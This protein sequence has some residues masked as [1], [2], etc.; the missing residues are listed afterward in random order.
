M[1]GGEVQVVVKHRQLVIRALSP[2][3]Q[4]RKGLCLQS[5][6]E[7]DPL[8][9]TVKIEGLVVPVAF[10]RDATGRVDRVIV[11]PPANTAF[12]RRSPLRN[13][14]LRLRL[15]AAAIV[16]TVLHRSRSKTQGR[17]IP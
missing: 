1:T 9:F 7:T 2:I 12:Y 6:E 8:L 15:A 11:G 14:R 16:A 10:A 4:V 17:A 5:T 13:S 3:R